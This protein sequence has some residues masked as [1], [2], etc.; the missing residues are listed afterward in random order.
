MGNFF[1]LP[2][3]R[4]RKTSQDN[5]L[6]AR[7]NRASKALA[8]FSTMPAVSSEQL[9]GRY[10]NLTGSELLTKFQEEERL[11]HQR[12]ENA[13]RRAFE[14]RTG[15]TEVTNA[16]RDLNRTISDI[17]KRPLAKLHADFE[18]NVTLLADR[19]ETLQRGD[20]P[21]TNVSHAAIRK[22]VES[23]DDIFAID[24]VYLSEQG[25]AKVILYCVSQCR[26]PNG[27]YIAVDTSV[28]WQQSLR[29]LQDL[30]AIADDEIKVAAKEAEP[31]KEK[32]SEVEQV[33]QDFN[34]SM[35]PVFEGW[36]VDLRN[37]FG[38]VLSEPLIREACDTLERLNHS[39]LDSFGWDEVRRSMHRRGLINAQNADEKLAEQVEQGLI[40]TP[41]QFMKEAR[42]ATLL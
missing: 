29:R 18:K 17:W 6:T 27:E 32:L 1:A 19:F 25:M 8:Q 36:I 24:G 35:G 42:K 9:N 16:S 14:D 13:E 30:R 7:R 11:E 12:R 10:E 2:P 23:L 22:T 15:I 4:R 39:P 38:V 5:S 41:H 3:T 37:R 40:Q 33:E 26:Q 28:P 20:Q 34:R 31:A 21:I